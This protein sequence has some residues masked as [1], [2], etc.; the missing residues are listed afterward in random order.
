MPYASTVLKCSL[1]QEIMTRLSEIFGTVSSDPQLSFKGEQNL[2]FEVRREAPSDSILERKEDGYI[3]VVF[4]DIA[5]AENLWKLN[6]VEMVQA[7]LLHNQILRQLIKKYQ[8][9]STRKK[10]CGLF[11]GTTKIIFYK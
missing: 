6:P 8:V 11:E 9:R 5:Q 2:Y 1:V 4:T 10:G 3:T 7:I